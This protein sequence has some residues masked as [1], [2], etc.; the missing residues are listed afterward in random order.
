MKTFGGKPVTVL[1]ETKQIGD[2]APNFKVV[3]N[4][5]EEKHLSDYKAKY[6][7]LNVVPSLDTTVCDRQARTV[8]I[9]LAERKDMV[10]I[11]ISNDLPFTQAKWCGS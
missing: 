3:D 10:V 4:S 11:T 2:L 6:V 7:I 5:F 9:E 8:N 1:G